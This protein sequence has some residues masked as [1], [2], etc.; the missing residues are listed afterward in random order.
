MGA[1]ASAINLHEFG[2]TLSTWNIRFCLLTQR[3]IIFNLTSWVSSLR[4]LDNWFAML[5]W[6][7]ED[8]LTAVKVL[9][10]CSV[11][12][13]EFLK[14]SNSVFAWCTELAR[15]KVFGH[16]VPKKSYSH[17]II[18]MARSTVVKLRITIIICNFLQLCNQW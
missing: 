15:T 9:S 3:Y 11:L 1:S 7:T 6:N 14:R 17:V 8:R 13:H 12:T 5:H 10:E 2:T 16:K 18:I 4:Y